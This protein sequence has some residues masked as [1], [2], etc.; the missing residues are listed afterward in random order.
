MSTFRVRPYTRT[1]GRT[2]SN[3]TLAIETIVTTN[4][5]AAQDA[6][7][8]T[9]EHRII[10]DLCRHPHSVAEVAA[11]LRLP[12]GVVRVLLAD[13]SD[14]SLIN[15]HADGE[16]DEDGRP[17]ISLMERVLAGLQRI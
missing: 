16:G 13:M 6:L 12:L 11:L 17:S 3:T 15:V 2:R 9:A 5:R 1:G 8:S 14:L 10:S 4:E 7:T